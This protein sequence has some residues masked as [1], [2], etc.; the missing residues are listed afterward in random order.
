MERSMK[1][2]KRSR[3]WIDPLAKRKRGIA[4][5]RNPAEQLSGQF[6]LAKLRQSY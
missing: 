2:I 5:G 4:L 6:N 1:L 3:F